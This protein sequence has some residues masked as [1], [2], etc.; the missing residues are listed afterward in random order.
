MQRDPLHVVYLS[1]ADLERLVRVSPESADEEHITL[2]ECHAV[3]L[4]HCKHGLKA[5][6]NAR[7]LQNLPCSGLVQVLAL[8]HKPSGHLPHPLALQW[9]VPLLNHQHLP[10]LV[11]HKAPDADLMRCIWR[12]GRR[13][14]RKPLIEHEVFRLCVVVGKA[15][16]HGDGHQRGL[17]Q[18]Y[19]EPDALLAK[20]APNLQRPA[21]GCVELVRVSGQTIRDYDHAAI[22]V[23]A[24]RQHAEL[25]GLSHSI[26]RRNCAGLR[27]DGAVHC[28]R[29]RRGLARGGATAFGIAAAGDGPVTAAV[30][31]LPGGRIGTRM[32]PAARWRYEL[33]GLGFG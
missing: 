8:R 15:V 14:V 9:P 28:G 13:R 17:L 6:A 1:G 19:A 18:G 30:A 11:E 22:G 24:S 7:L 16:L 31:R 4:P 5:G 32:P 3:G 26:H 29:A 23:L 2:S 27:C 21:E 12:Q 20:L 10:A 25:P 33:Y